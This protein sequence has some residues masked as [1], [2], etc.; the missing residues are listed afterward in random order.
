MASLVY[1]KKVSEQPG[2]ICYSFGE[3]PEE[4]TRQLTMDT[5]TLTS[6]PD[7]GQI[8]YAYLKASRKINSVFSERNQWPER[9]M[10][11]S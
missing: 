4:M 5:S 9:G 2:S 1:F 10:S 8:D 3:D 6:T 11:V 7:D